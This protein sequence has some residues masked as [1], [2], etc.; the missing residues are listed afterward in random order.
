MGDRR[1]PLEWSLRR[2]ATMSDSNSLLWAGMPK[3][4][5]RSRDPRRL[6][7]CGII[8]QIERLAQAKFHPK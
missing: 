6:V 2:W 3:F 1:G 4:S 8:S 5:N 7:S